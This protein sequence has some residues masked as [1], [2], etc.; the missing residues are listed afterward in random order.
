[1]KNYLSG[2]VF[3]LFIIVILLV[4]SVKTGASDTQL[5]NLNVEFRKINNEIMVQLRSLVNE[6]NWQL[7]YNSGQKVVTINH[8]GNTLKLS[9]PE[10]T[11]KGEE[12]LKT[13]EIVEGRTYLGIEDI[14]EIIN[15]LAVD[16]KPALLTGLYTD[17]DEYLK[18]EEITAY[19]KAYNISGKELFLDFSS[20]QRYD[21]WLL[22]D[23]GEVWRWSDGKFFTMA[24]VR[25]ELGAGEVLEYEIQ[26]PEDLEKGEYVLQGELKT[27]GSLLTL[28]SL[29]FRIK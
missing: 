3:L 23:G 7:D 21:L 14:Q 19:I 25:K 18:G 16:D 12:M 8:N 4:Q 20:G 17:K 13:P 2:I 24:L 11:L 15:R 26:L 9:I 1:M 10:G 28:N 27:I 6:L 22:Q 29:N 5:R